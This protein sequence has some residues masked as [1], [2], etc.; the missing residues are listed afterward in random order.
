MI[1]DTGFRHIRVRVVVPGIDKP[2]KML[3]NLF[4]NPEVTTTLLEAGTVDGRPFFDLEV[5]GV[6][7]EV[8]RALDPRFA[9][10]GEEAP[11]PESL[12]ELRV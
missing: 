11:S 5:F 4:E 9:G 6:T 10:V 3:H 8:N 7:S 12:V 1:D 2:C